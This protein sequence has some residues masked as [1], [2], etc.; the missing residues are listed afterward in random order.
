MNFKV[1]TLPETRM[2]YVNACFNNSFNTEP[3]LVRFIGHDVI[4]PVY[5]S[6]TY[7]LEPQNLCMS[8]V[9]RNHHN[10]K[11]NSNL[12]IEQYIPP[13]NYSL[14]SIKFD[15]LKRKKTKTSASTSKLSKSKNNSNKMEL[16]S[17][18]EKDVINT[19]KIN[20]SAHFFSANQICLVTINEKIYTLTVTQI[21]GCGSIIKGTKIQV[22][23]SDYK[24]NLI[25]SKLLKPEL[26]RDNYQFE[27]IGIGGLGK[28]MIS[29]FRE[30]LCT[31]ACRP[32]II[33]KLGIKHVKGILLYGPPGTGKTLIAR[34]IGSLIS[35]IE[36]IVVNGPELLN[37]YVGESESNVRKMFE[38][39]EEDFR[40]NGNDSSLHVIIFDEIDAICKA[41]AGGV[42]VSGGG[43][44]RGDVTDSMVNQL[45]TKLDG[46]K[47][48]PNIF[49]IAMTN[50][51][52]LID[53]ALLRPGRIEKHIKIGFPNKEGR[54]EIFRIHTKKMKINGMLCDDIDVSQCA[55]LTEGFSGAEIKA[56]VTCASSYNLYNL[57]KDDTKEVNE[58]DVLVTMKNMLDAIHTV[59]LSL[60]NSYHTISKYLPEEFKILNEEYENAL[61]SIDNFISYDDKTK[62]LKSLMLF[63]SNKTGKSTLMYHLAFQK[64]IKCT[65]F[66]KA[67]DIIRRHDQDRSDFLIQALLDTHLVE[68]SLLVID[69][70]DII[71]N[72]SK[73]GHSIDYSRIILQTLKT[74]LKTIPENKQNQ[75]IIVCICGEYAIKEMIGKLFDQVTTLDD[76]LENLI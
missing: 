18:H 68:Q 69:D 51:K 74:M 47:E 42:G 71:I 73:Y 19:I 7:T 32:E 63:G 3:A 23:S 14:K 9:I 26:F 34:N 22:E 11:V 25:S 17:L 33:D 52:D 30:T 5:K 40:K 29:I 54:E 39:A 13:T 15:L 27:N 64:K 75:L 8:D 61:N 21:V 38:V 12:T 56:V 66:I 24:I 41:R 55:A 58:E 70:I 59:E 6:S 37:K 36:P 48:I 2:A 31:R 35:P 49:L 72:Y 60:N 53:P 28:E 45:L 4:Y 20:M 10:L 50:R 1:F 57:M 76:G 46:Y 62:R 16:T 44:T 43:G 67:I 65:K